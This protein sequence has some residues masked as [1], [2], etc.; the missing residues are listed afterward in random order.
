MTQRSDLPPTR[1]MRHCFGHFISHPSFL[2]SILTL[3][4]SLQQHTMPFSNTRLALLG[5]LV[6][7]YAVYV[8]YKM[9]HLPQDEEFEALCDIEQI[10][11]S[12]RYAWY[13]Y[14][15]NDCKKCHACFVILSSL[16][17]NQ[18]FSL[19]ITAPSLNCPKVTSCPTLVLCN[20]TEILISRMPSLVLPTIPTCYFWRITFLHSL[21]NWQSTWHFS[22]QSF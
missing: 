15:V 16:L 1:C 13:H 18:Y 17:F 12:C 22:P 5:L 10:G 14:I 4:H 2:P 20:D 9:K 3:F 11:A 6:S 21:P 19:K 8:E 7:L